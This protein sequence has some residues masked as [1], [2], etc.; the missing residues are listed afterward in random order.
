[1]GWENLRIA[2]LWAST[3]LLLWDWEA[4]IRAAYFLGMKK[5]PACAFFIMPF[6]AAWQFL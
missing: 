3:R 2:L 6:A 4:L 5:N 1:M